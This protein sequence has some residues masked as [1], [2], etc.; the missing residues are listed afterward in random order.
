MKD[1]YS[2]N[3]ETLKETEDEKNNGNISCVHGL[4][5]L[6][7]YLILI[8][9]VLVSILPKEICRDNANPIKISVAELR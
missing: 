9:S 2:E 7:L 4:L 6:L 8:V 1:L 5:E 3:Y